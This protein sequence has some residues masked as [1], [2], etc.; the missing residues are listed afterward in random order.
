[1]RRKDE[2]KTTVIFRATLDVVQRI[3]IAGITM[4]DIARQANIATGTIYI[5]FKN[6]EVLLNELYT[7]LEKLPEE[8]IIKCIDTTLSTKGILSAIW[9]NYLNHR[10]NFYD[11]SL[12]IEQH[13]YSPYSTPEQKAA[14]DKLKVFSIDVMNRGKANGEIAADLDPEMVFWAITGF[15]RSLAAEHKE[16]RYPLTPERTKAAFD[17]NWKMLI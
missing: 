4:A 9:H 11:E 2:N 17:L 8:R 3:G 14:V 15:I 12:F 16:G 10:I 7:H 1:M 13:Y 5:Y 6:K